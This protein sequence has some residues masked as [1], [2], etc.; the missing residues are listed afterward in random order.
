MSVTQFWDNLPATPCTVSKPL[1]SGNHVSFNLEHP[2]Q[3]PHSGGHLPGF[4]PSSSGPHPPRSSYRRT[5][6][7]ATPPTCLSPTGSN[8]DSAATAPGTLSPVAPFN[9]G[10][11][12][13]KL[14]SQVLFTAFV[15]TV[16]ELKNA[17]YS[18]QS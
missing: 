15:C 3:R 10:Y 17:R 7:T 16:L 12:G 4:P 2:P 1:F 13:H 8:T 5:R 18:K 14:F 6:S 9:R 11:L